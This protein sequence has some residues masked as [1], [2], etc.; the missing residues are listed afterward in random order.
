[1][2]TLSTTRVKESSQVKSS[3]SKPMFYETP[4]CPRPRTRSAVHAWSKS[5]VSIMFI[6]TKT[7]SSHTVKLYLYSLATVYE[8][9][10]LRWH[11]MYAYD[12]A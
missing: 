2:T 1:V 5:S 6:F 9:Q 8:R 4:S 12:L 3:Q 10:G 7:D 11:W